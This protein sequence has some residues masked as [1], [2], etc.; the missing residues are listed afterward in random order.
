MGF[1]KLAIHQSAYNAFVSYNLKNAISKAGAVATILKQD[2]LFAKGTIGVITFTTRIAS[3]AGENITVEWD[4][5]VVPVGGSATD[6]ISLVVVNGT[7]GVYLYLPPVSGQVRTSSIAEFAVPTGFM[8]LGDSL[9]IYPFF[10]NT[11]TGD[12]SDS[13]HYNV[14]VTT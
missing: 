12:V 5:S 6:D 2:L 8:S 7:T 4:G 10:S 11:I 1:K 14:T 13:N 9:T 3:L